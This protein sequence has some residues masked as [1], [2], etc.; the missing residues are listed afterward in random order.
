[1]ATRIRQA[2]DGGRPVLIED[3]DSAGG[4][5]FVEIAKNLAAQISVRNMKDEQEPA[6]RIT[7]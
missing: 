6:V 4:A 5:A 2:S 7:F 3:P 1:L